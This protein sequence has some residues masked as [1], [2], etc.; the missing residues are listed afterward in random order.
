MVMDGF[1][2]GAAAL[3]AQ[4]LCPDVEIFSFASHLSSK[5]AGLML[6]A[7]ELALLDLEMR[8]GRNRRLL[9]AGLIEVAMRTLGEMATLNPPGRKKL[10]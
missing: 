7:P 10:P 6:E 9:G 8:L 2:S 5:Q 4:D 1:I 3:L